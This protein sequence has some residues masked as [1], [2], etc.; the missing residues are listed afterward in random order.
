[1]EG[2]RLGSAR[3]VYDEN[4]GG[5]GGAWQSFIYTASPAD[6]LDAL[7]NIANKQAYQAT[8]SRKPHSPTPPEGVH[9]FEKSCHLR[10]PKKKTLAQQSSSIAAI[11][12]HTVR[13]IF[14]T[15]DHSE[16]SFSTVW[17]GKCSGGLRVGYRGYRESGNLLRKNTGVRWFEGLW[18]GRF[19]LEVGRCVHGYV[20]IKVL[21]YDQYTTHSPN[22]TK[23]PSTTYP[24][25]TSLHTNLEYRAQA[26]KIPACNAKRQNFS[27]LPFL[28]QAHFPSLPPC[29][30]YLP[31][32]F[33]LANRSFLF[34]T[35]LSP[36][37][38]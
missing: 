30:I 36:R 5:K 29:L 8:S 6:C 23:P 18:I 4:I 15:C 38:A 9:V 22:L 11:L 27:N 2:K 25:E 21:Y 12:G 32:Y 19:E 31:T 7:S 13:K 35:H 34:Q 37:G 17:V 10:I 16:S 20:F 14:W 1:M 24:L 26:R 3:D 28:K 33:T